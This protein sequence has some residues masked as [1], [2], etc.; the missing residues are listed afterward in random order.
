MVGDYPVV[1]PSPQMSFLLLTSPLKHDAFGRM[2]T[3]TVNSKFSCGA[4]NV[5]FI[6]I[7][8]MGSTLDATKYNENVVAI[9]MQSLLLLLHCCVCIF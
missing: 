6:L 3:A 1:M 2:E 9:V 8:I 4:W 5:C 7:L